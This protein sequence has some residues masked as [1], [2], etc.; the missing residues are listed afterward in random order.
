MFDREGAE[1]A[2]YEVLEIAPANRLLDLDVLAR[3]REKVVVIDDLFDAPQ[4]GVG[5]LRH[6]ADDIAYTLLARYDGGRL[7]GVDIH[8]DGSR[9]CFNATLYAAPN[10]KSPG[11]A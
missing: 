5:L 6:R 3:L 9:N 10:P 7:L 4:E 8:R 11:N 1:D 2:I